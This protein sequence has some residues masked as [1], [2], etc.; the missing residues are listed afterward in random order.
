MPGRGSAPVGG[1]STLQSTVARAV[2]LLR[3]LLLSPSGVALI[4]LTGLV[5]GAWLSQRPL[6]WL[7]ALVVLV[8][9]L[10]SPEFLLRARLGFLAGFVHNAQ[11]GVVFGG[12]YGEGGQ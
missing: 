12:R 2:Q 9:V 3:F 4:F 10:T 8:Q 7:S 1:H 5:L 6:A 11:S